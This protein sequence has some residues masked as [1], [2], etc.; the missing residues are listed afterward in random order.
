MEQIKDL[1]SQYTDLKEKDVLMIEGVAAVLQLLANLE[2][3]DVFIDCPTT[4]GEAIVVA[5]AKPQ[6]A[7]S[8]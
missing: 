7:P 8:S 5:E 6:D 4:D 3:A 2:E 1:C